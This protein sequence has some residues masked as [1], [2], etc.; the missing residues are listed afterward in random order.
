VVL[1]PVVRPDRVR[2][3]ILHNHIDLVLS[4]ALRSRM[5]VVVARVPMPLEGRRE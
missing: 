5:D 3:R 2:Y 1:I 4:R